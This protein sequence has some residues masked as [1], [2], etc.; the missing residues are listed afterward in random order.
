M[1]FRALICSLA[2]RTRHSEQFLAHLDQPVLDGPAEKPDSSVVIP[3]PRKIAPTCFEE[4]E[5]LASL[6]TGQIFPP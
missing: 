4:A 5:V 2:I 3:H 1:D 6:H